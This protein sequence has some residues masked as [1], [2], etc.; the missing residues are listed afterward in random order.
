MPTP[1]TTRAPVYT[2]LAEQ[3]PDA[4][5]AD[6][7]LL[8]HLP[9]G[10]ARPVQID[11]ALKI[12]KRETITQT[13]RADHTLRGDLR[14]LPTMRSPEGKIITREPAEHGQ[15]CCVTF[16]PTVK[17]RSNDQKARSHFG[18]RASDLLQRGSGGRIRT[19][20]LWVMSRHAAVSHRRT[21]TTDV[22]G[23]QPVGDA[24]VSALSLSTTAWHSVLVT[25]LVTQPTRLRPHDRPNPSAA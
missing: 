25:N 21:P 7:E 11:H 16:H 2:V 15:D 6:T 24:A 5:K 14:P 1:Q 22:P 19:C 8:S 18:N 17:S 13:P 10:S 12:L 3:S 9:G 23:D 20:D 4:A